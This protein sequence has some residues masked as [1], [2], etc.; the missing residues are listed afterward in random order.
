MTAFRIYH[1]AFSMCCFT[2][3]VLIHAAEEIR[4]VGS[5]LIQPAIQPIIDEFSKDSGV[6][7]TV[8]M[9]GSPLAKR[10][11]REG[12]ADIAIIAVPEDKTLSEYNYSILPFAFMAGSIIVHKDNPLQEITMAQLVKI[13]GNVGVSEFT[14]WGDLGLTGVWKNRKINSLVC[15]GDGALALGLFEY[16]ALEDKQLNNHVLLLEQRRDVINDVAR[17]PSSIAIVKAPVNK[18]GVRVIPIASGSGETLEYSFLPTGENLAFGAYPLRLR[19]VL[20][21]NPAKRTQ[22]LD[23]LRRLFDAP[24]PDMLIQKGFVPLPNRER[25]RVLLELDIGR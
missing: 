24:T 19:F 8:E 9:T 16:I 3:V 18:H 21:Y 11:I 6:V 7:C 10:A 20:C 12:K 17:K 13:Y 22:M 1:L 14:D 4:I 23:L 2:Q 15:D 5:D 25:E